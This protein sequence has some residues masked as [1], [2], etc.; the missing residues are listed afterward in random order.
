MRERD[1]PKASRLLVLRVDNDSRFMHIAE[2]GE[3]ISEVRV[4]GRG[5]KTPNEDFPVKRGIRLDWDPPLDITGYLK[6]RLP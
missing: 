6:G 5:R 1:E 4:L 2:L 3:V